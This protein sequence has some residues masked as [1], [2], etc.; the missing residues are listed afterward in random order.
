MYCPAL[1]RED[2]LEVQ[3]ALIRSNPL[4][5]LIS[6]GSTGLVA[7][8]LPFVLKTGDSERGVLQAHIARANPQWRELDDQA[9][10]VVF[11]GP[12]AYVSP[13]LY[14]TKKETGKVVP[15]WNYAMVQARGKSRLRDSTDWLS[16]QL[17]SLTNGREATRLQPWSVSDAPAAYVEAQKKAIV[18]IEIEIAVLEG[19]WKVSQNQPEVNRRSVAAGFSLEDSTH[20]MAELVRS[21]GKLE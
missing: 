15:T 12:D 6:H 17:S 13:S 9:V 3:H 7:N 21:Y 8:L 14:A 20:Q 2:R 18:G 11:R 19:K 10:L 16:P 5:L 1:F 4:G